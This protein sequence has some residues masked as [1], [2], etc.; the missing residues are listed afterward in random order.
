M[1]CAPGDSQAMFWSGYY[2]Y[3]LNRYGEGGEK[4]M[5][6]R[7]GFHFAIA[8]I[9]LGLAV[10]AAPRPAAALPDAPPITGIPDPGAGI[11]V[12][13]PGGPSAGVGTSATD[14]AGVGA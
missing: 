7:R 13:V 2:T 8:A 3:S 4:T 12:G 10:L 1:S 6:V 14:G 11:G 5:K 9:G